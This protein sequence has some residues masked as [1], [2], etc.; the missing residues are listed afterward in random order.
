MAVDGWG[1]SHDH[2]SCKERCGGAGSRMIAAPETS[3]RNKERPP[4][5]TSEPT[6]RAASRAARVLE[7]LE[8]AFLPRGQDADAVLIDLANRFDELDEDL[9]AE[10]ADAAG[11][12]E[13]SAAAS[14]QEK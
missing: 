5:M 9:Q 1:P 12:L 11:A 14:L 8:A 2:G 13:G 4:D 3:T 10:L 7:E 6:S